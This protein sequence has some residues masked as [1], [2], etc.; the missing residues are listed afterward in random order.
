MLEAMSGE[1]LNVRAERAYEEVRP[2]IPIDPRFPDWQGELELLL[3]TV[4]VL[5]Y[6]QGGG[7][8]AGRLQALVEA[9]HLKIL[10][11]TGAENV[12]EVAFADCVAEMAG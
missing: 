10:D 4:F 11:L 12:R 1:E 3:R 5:G 6:L 9:G 7:E 2:R 8:Y